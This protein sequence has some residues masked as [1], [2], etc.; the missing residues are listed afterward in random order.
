MLGTPHPVENVAIYPV[1]GAEL[2]DPNRIAGKHATG[3]DVGDIV[4][5]T[6]TPDPTVRKQ[7]FVGHVLKNFKAPPKRQKGVIVDRGGQLMVQI[8]WKDAPSS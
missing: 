6:Y 3:F 2:M 8:E 5:F 4:H 7:C 1:I